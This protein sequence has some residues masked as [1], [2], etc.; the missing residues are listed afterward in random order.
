M[1]SSYKII[2]KKRPK[3]KRCHSQRSG[4]GICEKDKIIFEKLLKRTRYLHQRFPYRS[5][6]ND[7]RKK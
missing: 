2:K 6:G 7:T 1:P 4:R 5:A 3:S